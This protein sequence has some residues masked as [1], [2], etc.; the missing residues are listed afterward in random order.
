MFAVVKLSD[1]PVFELIETA[2]MQNYFH[3]KSTEI[4][5]GDVVC[6]RTGSMAKVCAVSSTRSC[7]ERDLSKIMEDELNSPKTS[8]RLS[9]LDILAAV[10]LSGGYLFE[11]MD[12]SVRV[13]PPTP[14]TSPEGSVIILPNEVS[15][16][17][18][19]CPDKSSPKSA[20]SN[21]LKRQRSDDDIS[22]GNYG[23]KVK[24]SVIDRVN[25]IKEKKI[26]NPYS[27]VVSAL[28]MH[29]FSR[30]TLAT[31]SLTGN[32]SPGMYFHVI[33]RYNIIQLLKL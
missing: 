10:A 21:G 33:S 19:I 22:I 32:E 6:L 17:Q 29:K 11:S 23:T 14:S 13:R 4:R 15:N 28:L 7:L 31:H 8:E 18:P 1:S 5:S 25:E 30:Q 2:D 24:R 16:N 3:A 9:G 12:A 26:K 27:K 20:P